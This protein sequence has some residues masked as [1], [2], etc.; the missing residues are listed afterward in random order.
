MRANFEKRLDKSMFRRT[1]RR[2]DSRG[3]IGGNTGAGAPVKLA[4]REIAFRLR[5]LLSRLPQ[6]IAEVECIRACTQQ[7]RLMPAED[8]ERNLKLSIR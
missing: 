1:Q 7:F 3:R 6:Q 5:N 2:P 8:D 4:L